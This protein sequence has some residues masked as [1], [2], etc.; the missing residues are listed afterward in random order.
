MTVSKSR[1]YL[2]SLPIRRSWE[3]QS[4]AFVNSIKTAPV[5]LLLSNACL[6][7]SISQIKTWF[8]LYPLLYADMSS[9]KERITKGRSCSFKNLSYIFEKQFKMLT[10]L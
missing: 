7:F 4:N 1:P 9:D 8:V 3:I 6:Q 2:G 5:K 10:D